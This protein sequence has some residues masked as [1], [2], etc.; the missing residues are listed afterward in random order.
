MRQNAGENIVRHTPLGLQPMPS[1]CPLV[2]AF[3][4]VCEVSRDRQITTLRL[5]KALWEN[6]HGVKSQALKCRYCAQWSI[7]FSLAHVVLPD[8]GELQP[9]RLTGNVYR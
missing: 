9:R 2:A 4:V 1:L 8:N 5:G 3:G 7:R 6:R